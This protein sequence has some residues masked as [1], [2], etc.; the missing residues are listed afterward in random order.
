MTKM[1]KKTDSKSSGLSLQKLV[2][3][4]AERFW[5][6]VVITLVLTGLAAYG[7]TF[8]RIENDLMYMMPDDNPVKIRFQD[9]EERF[10]DSVGIVLAF[11]TPRGIY[12]P[13]LAR[14]LDKFTGD[15]LRLNTDLLAQRLRPVIDLDENQSRLLASWLQ[16]LVSD[17]TFSVEEFGQSLDDPETTAENLT[18]FAPA[19][20]AEVDTAELAEKTAGLLQKA[21]HDS[22]GKIQELI[23]AV[24]ATTDRRNKVQSRWVDRVLGL[25]QTESA[26]PEFLNR[27]KPLALLKSWGV[28]PEPGLSAFLD[29]VLEQGA[30]EPAVITQ[31]LADEGIVSRIGLSRS[32]RDRLRAV[33]TPARTGELLAAIQSAPKQIRVAKML[34]MSDPTGPTSK[35]T[36]N[37]ELRLK[38]WGFFEGALRSRDDKSTL[39]M[40]QTISNLSKDCREDLL[41]MV[42][43]LLERDFDDNAYE[44][45]EAGEAVVDHDISALMTTDIARLLPIVAAVVALFLFLT[46][47]SVAGVLYPLITVLL[48]TLWCLG[49]MGFVGLPVSIVGTVLPVL[50]VAVGSAYGIHFVHYFNTMRTNGL[51][52]REVVRSAVDVTGLGVL[53]AGLTTIA[54]FGSLSA[55]SII[56]LRDFGTAIAVGVGL[57][58]LLSLYL[59]PALLIKFGGGRIG[60]RRGNSSRPA[61]GRID[62]YTRLSTMCTNRPWLVIG[63]F[64]AIVAF[65]GT[66]LSRLNVE[67]NNMN[68]FKR[69]SEIRLANDFINKNLAGTVGLR[70]IFDTGRKNGALDP[71]LLAVL[72]RLGRDLPADNPD[73][74]KV[75]SVVDLIK[76]MNQAFHY[77]DP[78]YYRLP[79]LT[80]LKGDQ[81]PEAL[82]G[83]YLF[84]VDKFNLKDRRALVDPQKTAAVLNV[85]VKT[86]SSV[87]SGAINDYIDSKLAGPLGEALRKKGI[88]TSVSGIGALYKEA[89]DLLIS[90]QMW[91]V[92]LSMSIVLVLVSIT[93]RSW[94]YGL[95]SILPLGVTILFNFG[96]MGF[97]GIPL[98]PGT[99]ITGCVAVGIGVDYS[100][101]YLNRYRLDR[102]RGMTH[103]EAAIET[104]AGS[105]KAI[106]V[107]AVSVAAGFL[108][109]TISSFVPLLDLGILISLTM[110][111][112]AMGSLSLI[113]AILTIVNRRKTAG[114]ATATQAGE[115]E[116]LTI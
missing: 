66:G 82:L 47:R 52:R 63:L 34:D 64:L 27:D 42:K 21:A 12:Q 11:H 114:P 15:V 94:V 4:V 5:P 101:H 83:Q 18:D 41:V 46:L 39:L 56:A 87:V 50:L 89:S 31:T 49:F 55:N 74:G 98:D 110:I 40:I 61:D 111:L 86:A 2:M 69:N 109:L 38:A 79:G 75:V 92:A 59:I 20:P 43:A 71:E 78:A 14:K 84:Y 90:G 17:P 80:D 9:N 115:K 7:V 23:K 95:L 91:S 30:G 53:I 65:S 107:N 70:V 22:P 99:A 57:A 85:Q 28:A 19:F 62:L 112:T 54:G 105:G 100:I 29:A 96:L 51:S 33:L 3:P 8:L 35:Q 16:S 45:Y 36:L 73:V 97:A 10:G 68:F 88:K 60:R 25:T 102:N 77:N 93:M 72:E 13:D 6:L 67:M 32:A 1:S 116:G 103:L 24:T 37:L 26:W 58:L 104:A 44:I 108:V 113:P 106:A 48:S 81:T 76:K